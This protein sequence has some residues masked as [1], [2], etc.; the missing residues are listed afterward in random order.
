MSASLIQRIEVAISRITSG[1]APMRIPAD[2]T[3]PD[4]VLM[5]CR[6]ELMRLQAIEDRWQELRDRFDNECV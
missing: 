3:D 5:D 6:A 2:P 4:I 1:Q